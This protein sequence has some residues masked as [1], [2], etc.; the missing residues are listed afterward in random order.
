MPYD[1]RQARRGGHHLS[2][3]S[4]PIRS[5]YVHSRL[6]FFAA[7]FVL[8]AAARQIDPSAYSSLHYRYLRP[9]GNRAIAVTGIPGDPSS[10]YVGSASGGIWKTTDVGV[11]WNAIF[12]DQPVASVRALALASSDPNIVCAGTGRTVI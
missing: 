9:P 8:S 12:H 11:H 7:V 4:N 2:I 5:I 3:I 10:Y 6:V 1:F